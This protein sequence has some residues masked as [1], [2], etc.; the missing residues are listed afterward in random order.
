VHD[1]DFMSTA[2]SLHELLDLDDDS[3]EVFARRSMNAG[4]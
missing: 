1:A 4:G 3:P 2:A